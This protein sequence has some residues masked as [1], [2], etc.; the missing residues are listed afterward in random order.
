MW[1]KPAMHWIGAA[2]ASAVV[3]WLCSI[4]AHAANP[5]A[6]WQIVHGQ[7]VPDEQQHGDPKPCA[8]V[9]LA[10]GA[11]RGFAILKDL[12][13]ATQ[14]LLIPTRRVGGIESPS[15]L[16]PHAVNYF[17]DA[18]AAR[19]FTEKAAG[20]TMP[21]DTLSLAINSEFGRTQNQLHIHID[22]IRRDV[23]DI[24]RSESAHIGGRWTLLTRPL[25][26]HH[27]RALRVMGPALDGHDPF[28]L[29]ALGIPGAR[30][31]MGR[32][33]LVVAGMRFGGRPG[34]IIL[35][36]HANLAR[37]DRGSGEELQDHACAL[38]H[39]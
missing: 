37:G 2:C 5:N 13:G 9:D 15:L 4:A 6:L 1:I 11:A 7:C 14:F 16:S 21:R 17:A 31:A 19:T 39:Q 38:A 10:N 27:Y 29:L 35:E 34:F 26:G 28:V 30:A 18:W 22:C 32:Y 8:A 23:R 25:A 20:R 3:F 36:D 12:K 33:T 24:L